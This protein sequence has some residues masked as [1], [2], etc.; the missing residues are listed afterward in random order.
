MGHP[1][2][3]LGM[4]SLPVLHIELFPDERKEQFYINDFKSHIRQYHEHISKPHKHD[5]YLTVLFTAGSGV[6]EVD[7]CGYAV[8]PGSVFMLSPGQTHFWQLSSDTDGYVIIHSRAFY[9]VRSSDKSIDQFPFF[10]S[11]QSSPYLLLQG[12]LF[13]SITQ[14]AKELVCEYREEK[15]LK[16]HKIGSLL[17]LFYIELSRE[18]V[19]HKQPLLP[20]SDSYLEKIKKLEEYIEMYFLTQ[21]S[22]S[23][24]SDLMNMSTKHLNRITKS[25]LGKTT[26]DLITERVLLEAQRMLVHSEVSAS[27]IAD[28]L[29]YEDYSYFSRL[30]KKRLSKSPTQFGKDYE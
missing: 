24:Y 29:G 17:D 20:I 7:F 16:F 4:R 25:V 1:F 28:Y 30:F 21:K 5:F 14:L 15:L 13:Q 12:H 11:T 8:H 19:E 9:D 22:A 27:E 23:F 10:Y 26:T 18:Y 2:I 3:P 6:H